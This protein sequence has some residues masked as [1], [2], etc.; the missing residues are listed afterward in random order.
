MV[1]LEKLEELEEAT[2][3]AVD[4]A[5]DEVAK[6]KKQKGGVGMKVARRKRN[7]EGMLERLKRLQ[8]AIKESQKMYY[9]ELG[10]TVLLWYQDYRQNKATVRE[11]EEQLKAVA[12]MF[13]KSLDEAVE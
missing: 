8:K 12:E 3:Q 4:Q 10:R 11:L 5:V 6:P 13:G 1:E 2:N 7:I 9:A